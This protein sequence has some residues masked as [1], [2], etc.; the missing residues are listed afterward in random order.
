MKSTVLKSIGAVLAGLVFIG[1]THSTIDAIL[2]SIGVLPKGNLYV[3]TPLILFVIF[4]RALFSLFGCYLTAKLS[5]KDPMKHALVLGGI[6]TVLSATGAI[7]TADM[8]LGPGW[9]AWSLV[10][11][12]LPVAWL[13][14]KFYLMRNPKVQTQ[15]A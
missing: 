5:P 1:V 10:V 8:N 11:I 9:Y 15:A 6:G 13:G 7:V 3:S 14:G 2:E 12:A 4:Y